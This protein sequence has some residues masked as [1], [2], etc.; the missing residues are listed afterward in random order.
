MRRYKKHISWI[1]ITAVIV[2]GGVWLVAF[3]NQLFYS[4]D[5][6]LL[7]T[8]LTAC[9]LLYAFLLLTPIAYEF[10]E[11]E[12]VLVNPK[13]LQ[14]KRIRYVDVIYI[15]PVGSFFLFNQDADTIA[16]ILSYRPSGSGRKKTVSCHP[17][18]VT[19]F[20]KTLQDHCPNLIPEIK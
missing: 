16:V 2:L 6:T 17:K 4:S 10:E 7:M 5:M 1:D 19:D 8:L 13:P 9:G 15:D 18:N 14:S 3:I 20:V 11:A 12:L